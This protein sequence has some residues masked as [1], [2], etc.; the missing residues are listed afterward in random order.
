MYGDGEIEDWDEDLDQEDDFP[1][2]VEDEEEPTVPCPY[3]RAAIHEDAQ[4]CPE[5]GQYIS[6]E[7]QPAVRPPWWILI[8]V[9]AAFYAVYCWV[10]G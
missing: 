10:V 4:R 3:C 7:D 2:G 8:G 1:D 9:V 5:C 6:E